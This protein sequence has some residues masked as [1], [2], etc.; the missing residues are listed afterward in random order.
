MFIVTTVIFFLLRYVVSLCACVILN[1]GLK[2]GPGR[3]GRR[4]GTL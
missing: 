3:Q 2:V 1:S 4:L